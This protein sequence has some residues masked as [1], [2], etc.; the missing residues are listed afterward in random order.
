MLLYPSPLFTSWTK[1]TNK[2]LRLPDFAFSRGEGNPGSIV[3]GQGAW[4]HV[5][6]V[7]RECIWY[8]PSVSLVLPAFNVTYSL[9]SPP[10][11][12]VYAAG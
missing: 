6:F 7:L 2:H 3:G 1:N 5:I 4:A 11:P 8:A 9:D 12:V 10:R